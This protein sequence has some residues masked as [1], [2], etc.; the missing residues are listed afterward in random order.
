MK[1]FIIFCITLLLLIAIIHVGFFAFVNIKGKDIFLS[2]IEEKLGA[3]ASLDVFSLKFPF[4]IELK[5][6]SCGDISFAKAKISLI[7]PNPFKFRLTFNDVVIEDLLVKIIK[8]KEG[9]YI[10]SKSKDESATSF[11][12]SEKDIEPKT[13]EPK[14]SKPVP[15][16]I[17]NF[18][19]KNSTLEYIDLRKEEPLKLAVKDADLYIK[20]L[21]FPEFSKLYINVIASL[22]TDAGEAKKSLQIDGWIDYRKKDMDIL[23]SLNSLNYA[24]FNKFYSSSWQSEELGIKDTYLSL[25]SNLASQGNDLLIDSLLSI[26]KIAFVEGLEDT[27]RQDLLKTIVAFI[28]GNK[29]KA[30][31]RFKIKTKMDSPSLDFSSIKKALG[32]SILIN[33]KI[34]VDQVIGKTKKAVSGGADSLKNISE[35]A[36]KISVDMPIDAIKETIESFKDIF[37]SS[38]E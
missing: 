30:T 33:P 8:D 27:S 1:K 26:D 17:N 6:F 38:K 2:N 23:L 24:L 12:K 29:E 28:K 31:L 37:E 13:Y 21:I 7:F 14:S 34:I 15:F 5:K 11:E 36:K 20:N 19:L 18:Y 10:G 22:Q 25:E 32:G 9:L 4:E 35:D 3:K 16:T